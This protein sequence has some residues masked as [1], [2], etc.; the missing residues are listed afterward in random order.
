MPG[1][2]GIFAV[3]AL[4]ALAALGIVLERRRARRLTQRAAFVRQDQTNP[5][6]GTE[7]RATPSQLPPLKFSVLLFGLLVVLTGIVGAGLLMRGMRHHPPRT[8]WHVHDGDPQRG[9]VAIIAHG[10]GGCHVV[11]GIRDANGRVGPS[12]RG[13]AE[14]MYIGGQLPNLPEHLVF[15]LQ[16]PQRHAPGTAMPNL[17]IQEPEARDIAAYLY[18]HR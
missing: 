13:F 4:A 8:N 6:Q 16:N 7:D 10:C 1:L 17:A 9:R 15:W 11:P 5:T 2:M 12:L 3:V 14:Q 18:T